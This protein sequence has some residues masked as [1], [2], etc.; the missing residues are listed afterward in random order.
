MLPLLSFSC[1]SGLPPALIGVTIAVHA[2]FAAF[3]ALKLGRTLKTSNYVTLAKQELRDKSQ[4]A[5]LFFVAIVWS[6]FLYLLHTHR[7]VCV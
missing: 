7:C 5:A 3:A 4:N 1:S 6:W 2:A